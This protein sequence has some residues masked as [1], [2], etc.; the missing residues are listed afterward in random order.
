ME[1]QRAKLNKL[2]NVGFLG[3]WKEDNSPI[4]EA[5]F[6]KHIQED[7]EKM[8]DIDSLF[9]SFDEVNVFKFLC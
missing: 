2:S 9:S 6:L 3:L 8:E 7:C 5:N 1:A 4:L